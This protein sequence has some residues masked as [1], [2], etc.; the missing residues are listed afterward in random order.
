MSRVINR[1]A[2]ASGGWEVLLYKTLKDICII[3]IGEEDMAG[4]II[5]EAREILEAY[6]ALA[7]GSP[8]QARKVPVV[9]NNQSVKEIKKPIRKIPVIKTMKTESVEVEPAEEVEWQLEDIILV[10]APR[11][12]PKSKR[13]RAA[14]RVDK[15]LGGSQGEIPMR[16]G[17]KIVDR[18]NLLITS[19][20]GLQLGTS[21]GKSGEEGQIKGQHVSGHVLVNGVYRL[22]FKDTKLGTAL[23][24]YDVITLPTKMTKKQFESAI[25]ARNNL[26]IEELRERLE[27]F[28]MIYTL[29]NCGKTDCFGWKIMDK[30]VVEAAEIQRKGRLA[31]IR[32]ENAAGGVK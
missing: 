31:A 27:H 20:D 11:L 17:H 4:D 30:A 21:S 15:D 19:T 9:T 8:D 26:T 29:C 18:Q 16:A 6:E 2:E 25:A 12:A 14:V 5:E 10:P 1:L 28:G 22:V 24:H 3:P 23:I 32:N 13:E 7:G